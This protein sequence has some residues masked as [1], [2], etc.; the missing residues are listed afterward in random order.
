MIAPEEI[1]KR[2]ERKLDI[3][4]REWLSGE[5]FSP[6]EFP[7]GVLSKELIERRQQIDSLRNKSRDVVGAGYTLEYETIN[8]RT[9]ST[10]TS[11]RRVIIPSLE[12]YLTLVRKRTVFAHF[13]ADVGNIR[14]KFSALE[15]WIYAHPQDVIANHGKWDDLLAVCDYFL[16]NP[17]PNLYIRELPIPVHTKFIEQNDRILRHLLDILLSP[18]AI[19]NDS[20]EFKQRFGLKDKPAL[21]RLR[22]LEGQLDWQYGIQIDDISLT[23]NQV[24]H[25]LTY[26]VKPKHVIIVENLINFLT[27]PKVPNCVGLFGGGFAVH[28]L[29]DV[30]W[31]LHCHVIYWGDMDAHGFEILSDLRGIFPHTMSLM[32]DQETFTTY[33]QGG[34]GVGSRSER[35]EHLTDEEAKLAQRVVELGLRLEQEHI[36]QSYAIIR[37]KQQLA[38]TDL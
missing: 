32:M 34:K 33:Y 22:L 24:D 37:I 36:P 10:Q 4:L 20:S 29:R 11:P 12:D 7:V 14:Q 16:N 9:F 21:I 5:A 30:D 13:V 27:L 26:H 6:I 15:D 8:T 28:L 38:S 19:N 3:V 23:V 18:E 2:A 1:V 35:F 25:L 31:L 17:R